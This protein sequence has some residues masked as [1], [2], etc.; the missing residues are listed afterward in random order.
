MT[1][2][3]TIIYDFLPVLTF[4]FF[5]FFFFF[6]GL[7]FLE[8]SRVWQTP[9][10]GRRTY[11]PKRCG[12]NNKDEDNSSKTLNDKNMLYTVLNISWKQHLTKQYLYSHLP[13]ISQTIQVTYWTEL[14]DFIS[15]VSFGLLYM[16][17]LVLANQQR[18]TFTSSVLTLDV[19]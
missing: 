14:D 10:E 12:N 18:L 2:I 9:E 13:P 19:I 1:R 4:R 17:A 11:W 15:N 6:C 3:T 8:G 16:D 7:K 5:F